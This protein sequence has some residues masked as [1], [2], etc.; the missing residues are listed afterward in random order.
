[1][2]LADTGLRRQPF[3][4]DGAP[5]VMVPYAAQKA[6]ISFLNTTRFDD[7][8][9][10][11]LQGPPF[12]GKTSVIRQFRRSLPDDY[13]V[14]VVDG[15]G[16]ETNALLQQI[17]GQ[18]G[19]DRGLN[20]ESER[21]SM[22]RVFAMQQAAMGSA[23]VLIVENAHA[24][25][26]IAMEMLCEFADLEINGKS[27]LRIILVSDRSLSP[28]VHAP[29]MD[30]ISK[31]VSG[32]FRLQPLTRSETRNYVYTKLVSGGCSI[33]Q[34]VVPPPV[35][36]RLHSESGGWPGLIDRLTL[37]AISNADRCPLRVDHVIEGSSAAL[38]GARTVNSGPHLILT[39]RR[40]TL[41]QIPL[42]KPRMMIGRNELCDLRIA[43]DG[44]SRHHAVLFRNDSATII[45]D[46]KS[47]NG[48]FLNGRRVMRQVVVNNDII[49]IGDHRI[50]FKDPTALCRTTLQGA[51]WDESTVSKHI[52]E[53]RTLIAKQVKSGCAS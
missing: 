27:A 42:D 5:T 7:H 10:G 36:D 23:P 8:G 50:K 29:A 9:L 3:R 14:A 33:P 18:Y 13:A 35:C 28:I 44:A 17:L 37:A 22:L 43:S 16:V 53:F 48:T 19:Y 52:K 20:S 6:A 21:F 24:L 25:N 30:S 45:V 46:L 12:S 41:A 39:R 51:G 1:M 40:K 32:K 38:K 4:T 15:A 26:P 34:R 11:L 49:L 47:K 2:K 31:R